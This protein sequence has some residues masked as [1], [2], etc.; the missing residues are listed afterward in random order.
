MAHVEPV[1]GE[2][3]PASAAARAPAGWLGRLLWG[4]PGVFTESRGGATTWSGS[5]A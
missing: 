3:R 4:E 2:R 1:A 5:S